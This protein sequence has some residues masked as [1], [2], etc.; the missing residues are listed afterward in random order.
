MTK[1]DQLGYIDAILCLMTK[2]AQTA[3]IHTGARSRYDD[4][5]AVHIDQADYI[6]WCVCKLDFHT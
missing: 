2:P 5:Q 6:H 4:F 3:N 1:S